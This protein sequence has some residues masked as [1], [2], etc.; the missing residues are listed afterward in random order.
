MKIACLGWGSLIWDPR[1]LKIQ[2]E[3]FHDGPILPIEFTRRSNDDRIT[4]VIDD[5]ENEDTQAVRVLW[6][7][8]STR[9]DNEARESLRKREFSK[10]NIDNFDFDKKIPILKKDESISGDKTKSKIQDWLVSKDID[11]AI[12]TGLTWNKKHFDGKRPNKEEVVD[13]L[14]SLKGGERNHAEEYIRNAPPQI[15]TIYRRAIEKELGWTPK[16]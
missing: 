1:D 13:Y 4:L 11:A 12:W 5:N 14:K 9:D 7:L 6:A 16:K 8:V 15:D 3:W 2:R 10:S